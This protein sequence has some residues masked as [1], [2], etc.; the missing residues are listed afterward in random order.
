MEI[1]EEGVATSKT[2]GEDIDL[3]DHHSAGH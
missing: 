3:I 1:M 2:Q